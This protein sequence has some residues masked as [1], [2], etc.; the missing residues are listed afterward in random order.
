MQLNLNLSDSWI[1]AAALLLAVCLSLLCN[2]EIIHIPIGQQ[3]PENKNLP[4][5]VRG[6]NQD[7]VLAAYGEP[8]SISAAVGEPPISKWIY[9]DF[10]VY[11]ESSVVIHSVLHHKPKHPQSIPENE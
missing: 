11:F 9:E 8:S 4:R 10:T 2:A 7:S 3:A 5:P 6:M 1:S